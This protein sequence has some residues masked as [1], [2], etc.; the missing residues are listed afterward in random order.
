MARVTGL[1]R[2]WAAIALASIVAVGLT[3]TAAEAVGERSV[4][5]AVPSATV[6]VAAPQ[7]SNLAGS[8]AAVRRAPVAARASRSGQQAA[9]QVLVQLSRDLEAHARPWT[10]SPVVGTVAS[11]SKYYRVPIV[12]WV[13]QIS[14]DGRWGL[15]Q[16][17]YVSPRHEGWIRIDGL[18]RNTTRISV[19]IDVSERRIAV[20]R[21]TERLFGTLAAVGSAS[22]PTPPGRYFVTDR[23]AFSV[24][25]ALGSFAFGISGIQP[26]LPAGWSGGNQ[27]A[28]HGTNDPSSIGQARSAGCVRVSETTLARLKPL[29]RLGTPV[30]VVA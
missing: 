16:L 25:S 19:R 22:T 29:L 27:L 15:L 30:I 12:A 24:G 13:E 9:P 21:G 2:S 3:A 11:A 20:F 8:E 4:Q 7:A 18:R 14:R 17:P 28:I 1:R 5:G 23:V 6:A 10:G 26:R